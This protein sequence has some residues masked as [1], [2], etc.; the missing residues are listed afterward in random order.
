MQKLFTIIVFLINF[1]LIFGQATCAS[2]GALPC[3]TTNLAGTTVGTSGVAHGIPS[4]ST[5]N[6]GVWYSFIG[7]GVSTTITV[8]PNSSTYNLE[9]TVFSG[10][11][12]SKSFIKTASGST[13]TST[14]T[15]T[16]SASSGVTYFV[17]IAHNAS[18]GTSTNVG[19]FSISRVCNP[20]PVN[21]ECSSAT[22]LTVNSDL[23]C[24]VETNGTVQF[25][26]ASG[27]PLGTCTGTPNDDVWFEFTATGEAH[28]IGF[29]NVLGTNVDN[30]TTDILMSVYSGAC[31]SLSQISC[32]EYSG[33]TDLTG[34]T[35][36][37]TY[38]VRMFS[39]S[40]AGQNTTFDICVGTPPP[41]ATGPSICDVAEPFCSTTA[42]EFPN[43]TGTAAPSGPNY[44]CLNTVPNPA[45]YFMKIGTAGTLN[46][47]I[48][49][50]RTNGTGIDVD[51]A[52][53]GPF[54]DLNSGC[55][56]VA[57]GAA[58]I[59]SS[60]DPSPTETLGIGLLGGSNSN[61]GGAS[62]PA[63]KTGQSTPPAAVVGD[64][65]LVVLTNYSDQLGEIF[66]SQT[67][68]TG[69]CDCNIL[70][71]GDFIYFG[72]Q[73]I[74]RHENLLNWEV[75]HEMNVSHYKIERRTNDFSWET[76]ENITSDGFFNANNKYQYLDKTA[77]EEINYYQIIQIDVDGTTKNSEIII[78]DNTE[79]QK[80][81]LK[82]TNVMGQE[83]DQESQGIKLY[84]Y[85]DGTIERRY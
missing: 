81:L 33:S 75:V 82:I 40:A 59:Q 9:F 22:S 76:I 47:S 65:Y 5:S 51:F 44:A 1:S 30:T 69:S 53:W 19:G 50:Q 79:I 70:L 85:T 14:E 67:G 77:R 43:A 52:L 84:M 28:K 62:G 4:A 36:G 16:F 41:I 18:P 12:A 49:Q 73:K 38:K 37:Q 54:N 63:G 66:F 31:A 74:S 60:F 71:G 24:G 8:V 46:L 56:S 78:V 34:L 83:V 6:Y 15:Y 57:A 27:Q 42:Y 39:W 61:C 64:Y 20:P 23:A 3:P 13:A 7:T 11:C 48:S 35:A 29:D 80:T 45:W 21:D 17:Y 2:P 72:G 58:P 25:A 32:R 10:T 55:S 26:N 68:G